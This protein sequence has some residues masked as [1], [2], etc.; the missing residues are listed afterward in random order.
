MTKR[1]TPKQIE[2]T[3]EGIV[4]EVFGE[5]EGLKD[6]L[7]EWYD[8]LPENFQSGDKGDALQEAISGLESH[9]QPDVPSAL[10]NVVATYTEDTSRRTGRAHRC[11]VATGK[12]RCAID[13]AEDWATKAEE[14]LASAEDDDATEDD[15]LAF[16]AHF[17]EEVEVS[18]GQSLIDEA[19]EFIDEATQAADEFE[20][21]EFPGMYG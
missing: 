9:Y 7:Q 8:N 16:K 2:A 14:L 3:V 20:N 15:K 4:E 21:V 17:G 13:A 6:E 19:R 10:S 1:R 5:I 18:D 11:S 12:L